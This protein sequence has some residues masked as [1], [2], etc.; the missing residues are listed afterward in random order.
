MSKENDGTVRFLGLR[1]GKPVLHS[2]SALDVTHGR[3]AAADET[4]LNGP[5]G[6]LFRLVMAWNPPKWILRT[7]A[8]FVLAGQVMLRIAQGGCQLRAH[9]ILATPCNPLLPHTGMRAQVWAQWQWGW[10][11]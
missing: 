8:A 10:P 9:H 4:L 2:H 1:L 11:S 3:S 5:A 7:M 6:F